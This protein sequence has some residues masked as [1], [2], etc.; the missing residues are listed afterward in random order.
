MA[1]RDDVAYLDCA[2]MHIFCSDAGGHVVPS[3]MAYMPMSS[4]RLQ[5]ESLE[6]RGVSSA[7]SLAC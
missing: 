5:L 6:M 7:V 1:A 2:V 3:R 4:L